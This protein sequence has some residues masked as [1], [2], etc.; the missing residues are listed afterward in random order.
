[1][2]DPEA[3]WSY[4]NNWRIAAAFL[5]FAML[6]LG[7][8]LLIVLAFGNDAGLAGVALLVI[9]TFLL[10]FAVLVFLP[11]LARRGSVSFSYYSRRPIEEAERAVRDVI[12]AA[13][14]P[15]RVEIVPTRFGTPPRIVSAEG[16]PGR[17]RIEISRIRQGSP[18]H[19]EWTEIVQSIRPAEE[20]EARVMRERITA[21]LTGGFPGKE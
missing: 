16:I 15:A 10:V 18:E 21:L 5:G 8:G 7:L 1:M 2:A 6:L 12:E 4:A 17:F 14:R 11:R 13:G 3:E 20:A 9:A 19:G